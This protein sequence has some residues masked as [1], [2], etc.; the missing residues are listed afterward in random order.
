M[1]KLARV[2]PSEQ[3]EFC[4]SL[5][6]VVDTTSVKPPSTTI[7]DDSNSNVTMNT[8]PGTANSDAEQLRGP[9]EME[10]LTVIWTKNW[11]IAAYGA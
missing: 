10:S 9:A 8:L 7:K 1:D 3:R 6:A 5:E 2:R 4:D 11:L